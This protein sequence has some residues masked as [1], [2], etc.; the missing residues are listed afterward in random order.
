MQA[1]EAA[2]ERDRVTAESAEQRFLAAWG[3]AIAERKNLPELLRALAR[4]DEALVR[5]DLPSGELIRTQLSGALVAALA[6]ES[7]R[8]PAEL[9]GQAPTVDAQTQGQGFL[10]LI[11]TREVAVAPGAAVVGYLKASG[12]PVA[13]VTVPGDAITRFKGKAWVYVQTGAQSFARREISPQRS[14]GE[15]WVVTEGLKPGEQAVVQGARMLLSEE[16]K[17][18]IKMLD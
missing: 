14:Q 2:A 16:Q 18:H 9:I 8:V 7:N 6:D 3:P 15:D 5:V 13:G 17:Q 1:G 10:L 4:R 12:S 11:K